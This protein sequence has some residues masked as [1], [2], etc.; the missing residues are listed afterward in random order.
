M[1]G[2]NKRRQANISE[3]IADNKWDLVQRERDRGRVEKIK[4]IEERSKVDVVIGA[5]L[6]F[7]AYSF[8]LDL[9]KIMG[10]NAKG[11]GAKLLTGIE[12][13]WFAWIALAALAGIVFFSFAAKKNERIEKLN[14]A[15][16][17]WMPDKTETDY[18]EKRFDNSFVRAILSDISPE[19][20][21]SIEVGLDA[22]TV[23]NN[24][25]PVVRNYN[26]FG[27]NRLTN[28]DTKQLAYYLA[29]HSFPEGFTIYQTKTELA[30]AERYIGGVTDIGG[31]RPP[32]EDETIHNTRMLS[33]IF[34]QIKEI[35][36]IRKMKNP[37]SAYL[38]TGPTAADNGQIV[39]NKGFKAKKEGYE[40]L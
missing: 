20:T 32:E 8:L 27:F 30:G 13:K 25:G 1:A 34:E 16:H 17:I 21:D 33:K 3:L 36:R 28:Y 23:N 24:T 39:L 11:S 14:E 9:F 7:G 4:K 37:F 40:D 18:I 10:K 19:K 15:R 22:V 12:P 38:Q 6:L 5:I 35:F 29:S 31:D 26:T 2:M